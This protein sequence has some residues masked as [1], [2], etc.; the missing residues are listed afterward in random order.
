M[1]SNA[2]MTKRIKAAETAIINRFFDRLAEEVVKEPRDVCDRAMN[3]IREL[4]D[5]AVNSGDRR[6]TLR[7]ALG[8]VLDVVREV[9][10][11]VADRVMASHG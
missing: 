7:D 10:P 8:V 9:S 4:L 2:A 5:G 6:V 3:A 11:G 1:Q